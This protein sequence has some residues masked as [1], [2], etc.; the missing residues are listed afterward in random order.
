[1]RVYIYIYIYTGI[2]ADA[3]ESR[4]GAP[5]SGKLLEV[6]GHFRRFL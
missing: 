1:M 5:S 4:R 6:S 2:R 3:G